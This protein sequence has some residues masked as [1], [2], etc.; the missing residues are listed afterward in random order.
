MLLVMSPSL[1]KL[2]FSSCQFAWA[3]VVLVALLILARILRG[4]G[5][6]QTGEEGKHRA[7]MLAKKQKDEEIR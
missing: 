4:R 1:A 5:L 3:L 2:P 7:A 6:F